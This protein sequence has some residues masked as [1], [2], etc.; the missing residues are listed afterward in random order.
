M[1]DSIKEAKKLGFMDDSDERVAVLM[2]ATE[3]SAA[4]WCSVFNVQELGV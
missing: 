1:F 3:G 4:Y 2:P